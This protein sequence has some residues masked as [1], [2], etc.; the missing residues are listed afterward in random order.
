MSP[1]P[2]NDPGHVQARKA[3]ALHVLRW[4][5]RPWW[6]AAA[7][8]AAIVVLLLIVFRRPLADR[9]WPEASAQALR[10][11][12]A[13]ALAH[14]R[15]SATDGSGARE[16]YEAALAVD[17]DSNEARSG[18][19]RVAQAALAQAQAAVRQGRYADAHRALQLARSLSVPRAQADAVAAQLRAIEAQHAGIERLLVQAAAA[20]AAH[21]L[22]GGDDAALPIYR[23]ILA[24]QPDRLEALEGR[25]DALSDLLQQARLALQHEDL[26]QAARLVAAARGYDPG[27][28]DLP[29]VQARL[30]GAIDDALRRA[31]AALRAGRL[32]HAA[33]GYQAVLQAEPDHASARHGL[34]RVATA[35][36]RRAE[37]QASDFHFTAATHA[38]EQARSLAPEL[39]ALHDA[40]HAIARAQ[41]AHA[42][43]KPP[44]ASRRRAREVR[45]LLAEAVAAEKR[46]DLL[47]PPGDSA[48]D[49]LRAARALA[50]DDPSV[51]NE[52]RRLLPIARQCFERAL[53]DNDLGRAGACLDARSVVDSDGKGVVHDRRRLAQRWLAVG[54]ERLGAGDDRAAVRAL[55]RARS[56]DPATP[57]L[58][59]FR[60]RLRAA[61]VR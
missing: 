60:E 29:D 25:E 31:D 33:E 56:L 40:E 32:Q 9:I 23:R 45:Q 59:E 51:R 4:L 24:M 50:P 57:G 26:P 58:A 27:H 19:M 22:D 52:S 1:V 41:Q 14:G 15:L 10:D 21:R 17:P 13:V 37:Q 54:D 5:G 8:A 16:L 3:P 49:K 30:S 36:A 11:R 7:V 20:R 53:R 43:L 6:R 35:W 28:A 18:L 46:G 47:T 55:E 34:D 38:L 48:F 12:A 42:A 61:G 39:P 2:C 44:V